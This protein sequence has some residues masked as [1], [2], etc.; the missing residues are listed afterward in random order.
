[1]LNLLVSMVLSLLPSRWRRGWGADYAV[2][3]E[4][5]ALVSG[6]MQAIGCLIAF[7][8]RYILFL[9]ARV[10][11]MTMKLVAKNAESVLDS[12]SIQ[13]GMG[14]VTMLDYMVRPI[15]LLLLYFT[16]EGVV[17][18]TASFVS[19][20]VMST[21]PLHVVAWA[22]ERYSQVAAERSLGPRVADEVFADG[23]ESEVVIFSCRPK[24][25]WD[26][27]MTVDYRGELYEIISQPP[28]VTPRRFGYRLRPMPLNK[29]VRG[30]ER[31]N[32]DDVLRTR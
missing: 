31:F 8:V 3:L 17:R 30:L 16:I 26:H 24:P 7:C 20:E 11:D 14:F 21:M 18:F 5:G 15:S 13:F 9:D 28:G 12:T 32:P 27:L 19:G 4:R 23:A 1:M 2:D 25:G 29:I 22:G 10:G 6:L